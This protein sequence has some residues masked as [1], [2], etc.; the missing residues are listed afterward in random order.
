MTDD[1]LHT[2]IDVNLTPRQTRRSLVGRIESHLGRLSDILRFL[3][4]VS[5]FATFILS[6]VGFLIGWYIWP[7]GSHFPPERRAIAMAIGQIDSLAVGISLALCV[8]AIA[9]GMFSDKKSLRPIGW[10]VLLAYASVWLTIFNP[11]LRM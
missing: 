4:R 1:L 10:A 2:T 7:W 5:S 11:I 9:T 6:V 3:A 8:C